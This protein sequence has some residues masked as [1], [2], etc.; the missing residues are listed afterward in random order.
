MTQ[1]DFC[2]WKNLDS[3]LSISGEKKCKGLRRSLRQLKNSRVSDLRK[4]PP[5]PKRTTVGDRRVLNSKCPKRVGCFGYS[6]DFLKRKDS[7]IE[8]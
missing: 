5:I 2:W 1:T 3:F 4:P 6:T 7:Q 8:K